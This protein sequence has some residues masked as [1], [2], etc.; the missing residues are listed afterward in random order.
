MDRNVEELQRR[1]SHTTIIPHDM[2]VQSTYNFEKKTQ[3]NEE[4]LSRCNQED[5]GTIIKKR[6]LRWIGH[7]LRQDPQLTTRIS[8]H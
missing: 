7:V 8:L 2:H 1:T 3:T 5:M 6:Q 4:L